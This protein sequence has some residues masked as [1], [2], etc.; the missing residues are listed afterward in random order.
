MTR[1]LLATVGHWR[2]LRR[3]RRSPPTCRRATPAA[4]AR[5]G[6]CAVFHMEWLLYRPQR[7]LRLRPFDNGPTPSPW[8][9]P[10]ASTSTGALVGGTIG[11]NLQFRG[12]VL[13]LEGDLDW[14]HIKGSSRPTAP[15]PARP[16]TTGLARRADG[17]ATPRPLPAV[18]HRRRA[19]SATSKARSSASATSAQTKVGWTG[20]AGV[21]YAFIDNW[22]AKIEYLYVDLGKATCGAACSGSD[23]ITVTFKSSVVRARRELQV[24]SRRT[25]SL[26][27]PGRP[28]HFSASARNRSTRGPAK[29]PK[30]VSSTGS[31][32]KKCP[33]PGIITRADQEARLIQRLEEG[34]GLRRRIDDVVVGAVD[35]QEPR[36]VPVTVA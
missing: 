19:P 35:Q 13:G 7:R 8:T 22:S 18:F 15:A 16:P 10:A 25:C 2:L 34:D 6:L 9:R 31:V 12:F 17:S 32:T 29:P 23:P 14:T 36:R 21:E 33:A 28:F 11:Y 3:P 1:L 4:A 5:A 20:G 24:L 26:S 27:A 30:L